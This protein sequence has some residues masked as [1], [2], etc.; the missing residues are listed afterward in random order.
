MYRYN[1]K[2]W[3][4][5]ILFQEWLRYFDEQMHGWK[6]LLL[7]DNAPSHV[8]AGV[9]LRNT[10]I[11]FLPPNTTS[12]L[13]PCDAGIIASFKTHYQRKFVRCLLEQFESN[14]S[15]SKLSVLKAIQFIQES[16]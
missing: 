3:M 6:V 2:A 5:A 9:E 16:W 1:K 7:L 14:E 15:L 8:V 4:T 13:Q 11:K 12:R 10:T